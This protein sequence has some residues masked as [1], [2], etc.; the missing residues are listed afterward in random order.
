[1]E[2]ILLFYSIKYHGDYD[3]IYEALKRKEPVEY[4]Q[5]EQYMDKVSWKYTTMMSRDYPASLKQ[6]EKPPFVLYYYGDLSLVNSKTIGI[7]GMRLPTPFGKEITEDFTKQLAMDDFTIVSGMAL[8]ID[9][10]AHETAINH[11]AKSIAV[12]G[13]GIDYCYP[14]KNKE[15]YAALKENGLVISEYPDETIPTSE[16][17]PARTRIIAGL[18]HSLFVTEAMVHGATLETVSYTEQLGKIVFAVPCRLNDTNQGCNQMIKS[19]ATMVLSAADITQEF[20][21]QADPILLYD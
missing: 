1:M 2:K 21:N 11:S 18:S 9:A 12:M 13:S 19:G 6:L 10:I 7:V 4:N 20:R 17:F 8:G 5:L 15:I 3:A 16:T 14:K